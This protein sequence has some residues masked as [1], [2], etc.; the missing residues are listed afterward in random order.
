MVRLYQIQTKEIP[1]ES[2]NWEN[3]ARI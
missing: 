2:L 3:V 1:W